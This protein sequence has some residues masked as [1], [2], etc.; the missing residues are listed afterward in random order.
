MTDDT[1]LTDQLGNPLK[2]ERW[3][4]KKKT[5]E[6]SWQ[7]TYIEFDGRMREFVHAQS[8]RW[9]MPEKEL[10]DLDPEHFIRTVNY[11]EQDDTVAVYVRNEDQIGKTLDINFGDSA[12]CMDVNCKCTVF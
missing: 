7:H 8:S 6:G 9:Y 1:P 11:F 5:P 2:I 12:N 4:A 10:E 3:I